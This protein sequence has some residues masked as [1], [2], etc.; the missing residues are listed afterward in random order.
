MSNLENLLGEI[1]EKVFPISDTIYFGNSDSAIAICT[2]SSMKLLE[3]ISKSKLMNQIS[4]AGRLLSENKG[5]D[6][7]VRNS[8]L[9]NIRTI[10]LC[11][12]EVLGHKTGHSLILFHKNGIDSTGKIINSI[13]PHPFLTLSQK[14]VK[15]FQNQTKIINLIGETKFE[16]IEKTVLG[17]N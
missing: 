17:L 4:I 6:S 5:I 7:I 9:K 12:K 8:N 13:S 2:L 10:I 1:C 16:N 15:K 11:G 3:K 14:E